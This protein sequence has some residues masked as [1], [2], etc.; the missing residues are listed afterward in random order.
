MPTQLDALAGWG[1]QYKVTD[2]SVSLTIEQVN[3]RAV[4]LVG[5]NGAQVVNLPNSTLLIA[6][7]TV[8]FVGDSSYL[9][10]D[11]A[12]TI[13]DGLFATAV[14]ANA[15]VI[16]VTWTGTAWVESASSSGKWGVTVQSSAGTYTLSNSLVLAGA[17]VRCGRAGPQTINLPDNEDPENPLEITDGMAVLIVADHASVSPTNKVTIAATGGTSVDPLELTA[18]YQSAS[19]VWLGGM[20][21]VL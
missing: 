7:A 9:S 4:V 10:G 2:A 21:V 8:T 15:Q 17:V 20:W 19:V 3:L 6:G 5:R 16:R 13:Q 1:Q 14:T 11:N 12:A 18:R